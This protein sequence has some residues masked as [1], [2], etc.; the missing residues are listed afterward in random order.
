MVKDKT[1]GNWKQIIL[2]KETQAN[3]LNKNGVI[4]AIN[5]KGWRCWGTK[6]ALNPMATDPKDKFSYTNG[7]S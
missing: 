6:T 3:F 2:D 1:T 7:R 4:T 5:F